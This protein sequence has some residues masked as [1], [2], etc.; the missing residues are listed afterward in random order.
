ME[1]PNY[2]QQDLERG[3]ELLAKAVPEE[4]EQLLAHKSMIAAQIQLGTAPPANSVLAQLSFQAPSFEIDQDVLDGLTPCQIAI[5]KVAVDA[6]FIIIGLFGL[7][8]SA[9]AKMSNAIIKAM[10]GK[11]LNGLQMAIR[12]F[13]E[14]A[15]AYTKAKAFFGIAGGIYYAGGLGAAFKVLKEEM[16]WWDWTKTGVLVFLQLAAW[17]ASEGA[18]FIAEVAMI[19][20][21]AEQ[22]IEDSIAC[23]KACA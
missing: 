1:T 9:E 22:M 21:Q 16:G 18:A 12:D 11:G 19:I 23:G 17:F 4:A 20:M 13:N 3:V 8:T 2:T 5:G 7:R 6:V 10:G 14:A 15:T